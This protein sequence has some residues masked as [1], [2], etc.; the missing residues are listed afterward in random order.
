MDEV[1]LFFGVACFFQY[2]QSGAQDGE[3]GTQFVGGSG[4]EMYLFFPVSFQRDDDTFGRKPEEDKQKSYGG[5]ICQQDNE[6]QMADSVTLSLKRGEN[7]IMEAVG[8]FGNH[9]CGGIVFA[10]I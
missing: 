2:F 3:G 4:D 6:P 8:L 9:T 5:Q 7:E 10:A 1:L